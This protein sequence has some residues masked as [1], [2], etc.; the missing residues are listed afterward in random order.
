MFE[1]LH[2]ENPICQYVF[3]GYKTFLAP[4]LSL[5]L[6]P[7]YFFAIILDGTTYSRRDYSIKYTKEGKTVDPSDRCIKADADD[8]PCRQMFAMAVVFLPKR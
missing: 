2:R 3:C 7:G 6:S 4:L 1:I 8:H 5:V